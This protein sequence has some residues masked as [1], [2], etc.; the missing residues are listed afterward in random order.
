LS[1][2][3]FSGGR[4]EMLVSGDYGPDY[5]VEALTNLM[6]WIPLL[7]TNLPV[8]PFA[9]SEMTTNALPQRFYRVR[10]GP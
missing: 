9:W 3:A 7:T 10:L 8:T 4:F 2:P 6:T 1:A 5:T